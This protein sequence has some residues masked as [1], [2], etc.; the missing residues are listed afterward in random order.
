MKKEKDN[1]LLIVLAIIASLLAA[2]NAYIAL[3]QVSDL[4]RITGFQISNQTGNITLSIPQN[5]QVEFNPAI[6]NW[7]NGSVYSNETAARLMTTNNID[8][9]VMNGTWVNGTNQGR[10]TGLVLRNVGNINVSINLTTGKNKTTF[11][12][13]IDISDLRA[14]YLWNISNNNS[15]I[16]TCGAAAQ[17]S[18]FNLFTPVNTT[19]KGSQFVCRNLSYLSGENMLRIDIL[20]HV[21]QGVER[22]EYTDTITAQADIASS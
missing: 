5:V 13:P 9:Q 20:L 17:Y 12:L 14:V 16:R 8:I 19:D 1:T 11:F 21:P 18:S 10:G 3:Q 7:S 6:I 2:F 15:N 4:A 22:K